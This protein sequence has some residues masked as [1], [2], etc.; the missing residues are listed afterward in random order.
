MSSLA[1]LS[2]PARAGADA[3]LIGS[4]I[5]ASA[6]PEAPKSSDTMTIVV[7][8]GI[9]LLGGA[10]AAWMFLKPKPKKAAW[11][12]VSERE[13]S[14]MTFGGGTGPESR[15]GPEFVSSPMDAPKPRPRPASAGGGQTGSATKSASKPTAPGVAATPKPKPKPP[16]P[17]SNT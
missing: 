12:S 10:V 7:L 8:I 1:D 4:F 17:P 16:T 5:S 6:N 13:P 3:V 2:A 11:E 14:P 9:L 15:S